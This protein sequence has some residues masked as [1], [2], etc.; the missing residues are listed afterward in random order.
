M[1]NDKRWSTRWLRLGVLVL[2]ML[3]TIGAWEIVKTARLATQAHADGT[4]DHLTCY[5]VNSARGDDRHLDAKRVVHIK[6][7]FL[8]VDIEVRR[9]RLICAPATKMVK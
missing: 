4:P 6:D 2:M 9:L 1:A 7:Q 5:D 3:A 8:H